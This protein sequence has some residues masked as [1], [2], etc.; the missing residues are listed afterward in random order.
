[1]I[2]FL[3]TLVYTGNCTPEYSNFISLHERTSDANMDTIVPIQ[4]P[5]IGDFDI[6][7][8]IINLANETCK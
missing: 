4:F 3:A 6:K 7:P 8:P 2:I 1:M 5:T